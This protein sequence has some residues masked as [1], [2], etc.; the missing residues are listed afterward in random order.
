MHL[1]AAQVLIPNRFE[2]TWLPQ[3]GRCASPYFS[4]PFILSSRSVHDARR[5]ERKVVQSIHGQ[6]SRDFATSFALYRRRHQYTVLHSDQGASI[7]SDRSLVETVHD[8]T[9]VAACTLLSPCN[10]QLMSTPQLRS[11][12]SLAVDVTCPTL[13]F[14]FNA[15]AP[16]DICEL[17]TFQRALQHAH[18]C[19]RARCNS[20]V[21]LCSARHPR[22]RLTEY[23]Q[24]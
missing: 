1:G 23:A 7:C 22:A 5:T 24:L 18:C 20:C 4:Y 2:Q 6:Q 12:S 9:R 21:A 16:A 14:R 10:V 3:H 19:A 11:S 17:R 13:T 15:A 8:A